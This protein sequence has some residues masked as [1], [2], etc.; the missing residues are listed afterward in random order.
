MCGW[1]CE[2]NKDIGGVG[3][4]K[5]CRGSRGKRSKRE[6]K[7]RWDVRENEGKKRKLIFLFHF[8]NLK[9]TL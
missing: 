5:E 9:L 1:K 3:K 4:E 7:R 6:E 2:I 8:L